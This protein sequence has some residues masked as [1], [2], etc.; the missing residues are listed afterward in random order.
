MGSLSIAGYAP[1]TAIGVVAT[2]NAGVLTL[3]GQLPSLAGSLSYSPDNATLAITGAAPQISVGQVAFPDVGAIV[4]TGYAPTIA[5]LISI[6][7][8]EGVLSLTGY[9]PSL[10]FDLVVSPGAGELTLTTYALGDD[11]VKAVPDGALQLTAFAPS[12]LQGFIT[13]PGVGSIQ[14]EGQDPYSVTTYIITVED[15]THEHIVLKVTFLTPVVVGEAKDIGLLYTME[16]EAHTFVMVDLGYFH[17]LI[18]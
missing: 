9:Q 5:G 2:P 17:D 13:A 16:E 11:T 12:I 10:R 8:P 7:I 1:N 15:V 3:S 6:S 18:E 14:L 4:T